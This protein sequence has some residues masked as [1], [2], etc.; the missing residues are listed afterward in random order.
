VFTARYAQSLYKADYVTSLRIKTLKNNNVYICT[1]SNIFNLINDRI[2]TGVFLFIDTKFRHKIVGSFTTYI[3]VICLGPCVG[4][5]HKF[6]YICRQSKGRHRL[7]YKLHRG[8]AT[9]I[10]AVIRPTGEQSWIER[11]EEFYMGSDL[12]YVCLDLT[13]SLLVRIFLIIGLR[14]HGNAGLYKL[15]F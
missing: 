13:F 2:N 8:T 7:L 9:I 1:Y 14:F 11:W 6:L 3:S 5:P 10:L 4:E 15:Y 12:F